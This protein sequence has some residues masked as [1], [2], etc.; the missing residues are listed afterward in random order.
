VLRPDKGPQLP[1][2]FFING[3]SG[4]FTHRKL[5]SPNVGGPINSLGAKFHCVSIHPAAPICTTLPPRAESPRR[6]AAHAAIMSRRR[7]S[8]SLLW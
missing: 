4:Y 3:L 6:N 2:L 5:Y 8:M 1:I 7:S